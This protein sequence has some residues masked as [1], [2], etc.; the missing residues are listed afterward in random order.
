L[1]RR[2]RARRGGMH[3]D[4]EELGRRA[5]RGDD[6]ALEE[7]LVRYMPGL[8]AFV[9][10]RSG[11]ALRRNESSSDLVQSVCREVLQNMQHFRYPDEA[12][13]KRW[14]YTTALRK[15]ADRADH[16]GALKRGGG[17]ALAPGAGDT[18][19]DDASLLA[20]YSSFSTPSRRAMVKEEIERVESAFEKL[21]EEQREVIT[22]AHVVGLSRAEIAEHMHKTE[23]SVRVLLHR[24]LA[25]VSELL[26]DPSKG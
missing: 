14:L 10:L 1:R 16:Y 15:I 17:R 24:A 7:L 21:S 19:S 6:R 13:F 23:T 5:A 12:G 4:T 22:L 18:A 11:D 3:D 9:R 8:R 25:R 20:C 2:D 26:G